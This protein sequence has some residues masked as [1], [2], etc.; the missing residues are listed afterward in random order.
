MRLAQI[1]ID[2]A[3]EMFEEL[4]GKRILGR[5]SGMEKADLKAAARIL[6]QVSLLMRHFP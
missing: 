6:V 2:S 4:S 5:F 3:M 1:D